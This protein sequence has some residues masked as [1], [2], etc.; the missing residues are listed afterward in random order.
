MVGTDMRESA[1]KF[2]LVILDMGGAGKTR[3]ALSNILDIAAQ[4]RVNINFDRGDAHRGSLTVLVISSW[5]RAF[6]PS[7][8]PQHSRSH[9]AALP[10]RDSVA[11]PS[12]LSG[13]NG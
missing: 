11:A 2:K 7:R 12:L 3:R 13:I 4:T 8:L 9:T 10:T 6:R 1:S 5:L